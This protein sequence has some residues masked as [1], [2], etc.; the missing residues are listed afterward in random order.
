MTAF[1]K[2]SNDDMAPIIGKD[3]EVHTVVSLTSAH[4]QMEVYNELEQPTNLDIFLQV[5]CNINQ[6]ESNELRL[7]LETSE[8]SS[9]VLP[10]LES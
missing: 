2:E 5:W 1:T 3:I 6:N 7:A 4:R 8:T 9:L 10:S